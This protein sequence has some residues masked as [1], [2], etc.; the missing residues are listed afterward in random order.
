MKTRGFGLLV[1]IITL[2]LGSF[3]FKEVGASVTLA[4]LEKQVI[5]A[6]YLN[7][8][9]IPLIRMEKP[10]GTL[11]DSVRAKH[12]VIYDWSLRKGN[13][14]KIGFHFTIKMD[15]LTKKDRYITLVTFK[16]INNELSPLDIVEGDTYNKN[17][18]ELQPQ[19]YTSDFKDANYAYFLIGVSKNKGSEFT[20]EIL[21]K[22]QLTPSLMNSSVIEGSY[23]VFNN[24]STNVNKKEDTGRLFNQVSGNENKQALSLQAYQMDANIPF[25]AEGNK[26]Y[27]IKKNYAQSL[28]TYQLGSSKDFWVT[29]FET[30]KE[31][32]LKA[33]L[34]YTGSKVN[35]WVHD[36]EISSDHAK[37][38]GEEFDAKIYPSVVNH[39]GNESDVD[40]DGKVNL[41]AFDIQ[42]GFSGRGGFLGGYFNQAD[43]Y[44]TSKSNQAELLYIDTYPSL[45]KNNNDFSFVFSTIAHEYQHLVN[46]NQNVLIEGSRDG[47]D[48]W[49]DEAMSMAA[50]QIYTREILS[51]R[52]DYYNYSPSIASGHSL[53]YW[54]YEGDT[55][56]NY[57]LS[58]LFGQ[59][60]KIHAKQGNSIF[61]EIL[62]DK[63]NNYKAIETIIKKYIDSSM[64][65]GEFTTQ[66]RS[67]L[68]AK[69]PF[70]LHGFN[71]DPVVQNLKP[72]LFAGDIGNLRGG[73]AIA[74]KVDPIEGFFKPVDLGDLSY[75][76]IS[77]NSIP[78]SQ[79]PIHVLEVDPF[80]DHDE[81]IKGKGIRGSKITVKMEN[82]EI[83]SGTADMEGRFSIKIPK[84]TIGT[85]L[86]IWSEASLSNTLA[87]IV[88]VLDKT[89]P[90]KPTVNPIN[91]YDTEITGNAERFSRVYVKK[92]NTVI[93]SK[94]ADYDGNFNISVGKQVVGTR[95]TVYAEDSSGNKSDEVIVTVEKAPPA[96]PTVKPI[97]D[98]TVVV[99]GTSDPNSVVYI[100]NGSSLIGKGTTK[101][102]GTFEISIPKQRA[103][104]ELIVYAENSFGKMSEEELVYVTAVPTMPV[105]NQVGDH[106]RFVK[107]KAEPGLM[108]VVEEGSVIL[109]QS[110][111]NTN[112]TFS[113]DIGGKVKAGTVLKVYAINE[114]DNK[115]SLVVVKVV[116]KT[117][118]GTPTVNGVVNSKS[119]SI[120]GM[121][122]AGSSVYIYN[123]TKLVSKVIVDKN[124]HY[125]GKMAA[126]KKGSKLT[127]FAKDKAGNKSGVKVIV[128]K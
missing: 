124:G 102:N 24:E 34:L 36:D 127:F 109:G 115:S 59:Y 15:N 5:R 41:L 46:H 111:T 84:Q 56:A 120:S 37:R 2:L 67:A 12:E 58:Y 73:G 86:V 22:V 11:V 91:D 4:G 75:T 28:V 125:K 44:N 31:Y 60:V 106:T 98:Q 51:E 47:M 71:G 116:D 21:F 48:I 49:L 38:L 27:L 1:L 18:F 62:A 13:P 103:G 40:G 82:K 119:T 7:D 107:G 32:Q 63:N 97:T 70:G 64:S 83:G 121:A 17:E 95:L 39:F 3:P 81:I 96:T 68:I 87:I 77:T 54:D 61:K 42:D 8:S 9:D 93:S 117:A 99:K 20:D 66:F 72:R 65:F 33:K 53:L 35:V 57:S 19:F 94:K 50:E 89:P 108:I 110:A 29:D 88:T 113:V 25:Q 26:N 74:V 45:G 6:D 76:I 90:D 126:Q 105:V 128:V 14:R 78:A 30:E 101:T 79:I 118:P 122:E 112:G 92:G 10:V 85:Q 16:D 80:S 23:V 52:I 114:D 123:G 104:S 55:L 69:E 43:L 100:K